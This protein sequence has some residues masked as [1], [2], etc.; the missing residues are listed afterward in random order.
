MVNH[1]WDLCR[2]HG[3]PFS[4]KF[5]NRQRTG[6]TDPAQESSPKQDLSDALHNK[7]WVVLFFATL[8]MFIMLV[9]RGG[10]MTFYMNEYVNREAMF[11]F[12]SGL[13]LV[14]PA[15]DLVN[16]TI[17]AEYFRPFDRAGSL[18]CAERRL[19]ASRHDGDSFHDRRRHTLEAAY[20]RDLATGNLLRLPDSGRG[21][22][23]V[24]AFIPADGIKAECFWRP[25]RGECA[26]TNDTVAM[27][28]DRRQRR[29]FGMEDR[30][31]RHRIHVRRVV[32]ALK[33]GLGIGGAAPVS[34]RIIGAVADHRP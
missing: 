7:S 34:F 13:N 16:G 24:A 19:R 5:S 4:H 26:G 8:M 28:D 10:S 31:P 14:A 32:F 22:D 18:E 25:S 6:A 15:T 23:H 33:F 27:V 17:G 21:H 9:V 20:L 12:L 30:A 2:R 3:N 1:D 29:L 11:T